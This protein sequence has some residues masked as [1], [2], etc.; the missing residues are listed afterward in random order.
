M[1][2]NNERRFADQHGTPDFKHGLEARI[3]ALQGADRLLEQ[4]ADKHAK[5]F[6]PLDKR[7]IIAAK[8]GSAQYVSVHP[9]DVG[10]NLMQNMMAD[11]ARPEQ[12][13]DTQLTDA[14]IDWNLHEMQFTDVNEDESDVSK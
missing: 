11:A 9:F 1:G 13:P 3:Y 10:K 6:S 5:S 12:E 7:D 4:S 14:E 8:Y 2:S